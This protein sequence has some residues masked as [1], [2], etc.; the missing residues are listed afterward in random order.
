MTTIASVV[1]SK[2]THTDPRDREHL[3]SHVLKKPREWV[4][5]HPGAPV[6]PATAARYRRLLRRLEHGEPLAH[7]LGEAW[8]YGRPFTVNGH[9]LIPRPETELLVELAI[10]R[11]KNNESRIMEFQI[12]DSPPKADPPREDVARN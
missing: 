8:F 6:R 2:K 12:P 9:V 4:I 7:L 5:A 3:L 11:I 10:R 1:A